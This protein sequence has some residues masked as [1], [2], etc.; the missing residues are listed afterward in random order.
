MSHH[1]PEMGRRMEDAFAALRDESA[2]PP[3]PEA[4]EN[5]RRAMHLAVGERN[6][7]GAAVRLAERLRRGLLLHRL[8]A[9]AAGAALGLGAVTA[10]GWNAPVGAPLHVV[11]VAHE[12][13]T[14]SLPGID[15]ASLDLSYAEARLAQAAAGDSASAALGEAQGLLDDAH[16][17]LPANTSTAVWT[18]WRDDT[19]RLDRLRDGQ[20]AG[21][22]AE[23]GGTP[24]GGDDHEGAGGGAEGTSS[25]T[26]RSA[27]STST[28]EERG[29]ETSTSS[30][31][32]S[33]EHGGS[34]STSNATSTSTSS[35]SGG[36]GGDGGGSQTGG[37][38]ST[39]S[40]GDGSGH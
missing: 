11:Q 27:G 19:A 13:I 16:A 3:R 29:G 1:D 14:L 7:G 26:S 28:G 30:T 38:T 33:E 36:D 10:L 12:Q 32:Q 15:R 34:T 18:R 21:T 22:P 17:H 20:P 25:S 5:A 37:S 4:V 2:A 6:R 39:S 40:E 8:A 24:S 35:S 23:D 9:A 31:T